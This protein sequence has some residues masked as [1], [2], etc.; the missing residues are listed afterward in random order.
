MMPRPAVVCDVKRE[1]AG[2]ATL[3][4]ELEEGGEARDLAFAP[5][6]FN[7]LYLPSYGECAIS[8]SSDPSAPGRISHTIRAAGSLTCALTSLGAGDVVGLRG[9]FGTAWPVDRAVGRDLLLASGGIGLASLRSVIHH[10]VRRRSDFGRVLLLYGARTPADLL[11]ADS[12]DAWQKGGIEIHATVDRADPRWTGP[13]GAAPRL[14]DR[15]ELDEKKTVVMICGPEA[16]TR[17]VVDEAIARRIPREEI[18]VSLERNMKCAI[19]LCGHCQLG[20]H[21]VC[22]DGPIFPIPTVEPFITK[23]KI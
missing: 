19:G 2:V 21:F 6:Q 17:T 11:Y 4:L 8:I 20:P 13:V 1:T 22:K 9:P 3:T 14:F 5:G 12:Y 23:G 16:M 7:M 10:V 18:F 15:L